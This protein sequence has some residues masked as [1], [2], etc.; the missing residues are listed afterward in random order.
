MSIVGLHHVTLRVPSVDEATRNLTRLG[1]P[2]V[3]IGMHPVANLRAA[4]FGL[5][6][7]RLVAVEDPD[8]QFSTGAFAYVSMRCDGDGARW[9]A[10]YARR[11]GLFGSSAWV[12]LPTCNSLV[13]L[14]TAEPLPSE[15]GEA[16][17]WRIES[18]PWSVADR[19]A[20]EAEAARALGLQRC[21]EYSDL[22]F[23]DLQSTNALL[24]VG[25]DSYID[26]NEP[27]DPSSPTARRVAKGGNGVF[28]L[29]IEPREFDAAL[30]EL[31]RQQVPTVTPDPVELRVVWRD[32]TQGSAAR[33]V[34][35]DKSF[36]FGARIFVSEPTFPW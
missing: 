35:I 18:I 17:Y 20:A 23:P 1:L 13:E 2:V 22:V 33:I 31:K 21:V 5:G 28:A 14:I 9:P 4:V 10:E 27:T 8:G 11:A 3:D 25:P 15:V 32:G 12:N 30:A 26:F 7:H 19:A 24:F 36:T 29:V 6:A 34:S 16:G